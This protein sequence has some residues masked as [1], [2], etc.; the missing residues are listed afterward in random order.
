MRERPEREDTT[1]RRSLERAKALLTACGDVSLMQLGDS[2]ALKSKIIHK[3][4]CEIRRWDS[5]NLL[6]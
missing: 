6:Q 5:R 4:V 3:R 2:S 1:K